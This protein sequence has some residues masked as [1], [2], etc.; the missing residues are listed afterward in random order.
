MAKRSDNGV[1]ILNGWIESI[2]SISDRVARA[3]LAEAIINYA[4][5]GTEYQG[6]KEIVRV[7]MKTIS[8]SVDFKKRQSEQNAENG[9]RGGN[10]ALQAARAESSVN[11]LDNQADKRPLNHS[12]NTDKEKERD[13]DKEIKVYSEEYKENA[14]PST[15]STISPKTKKFDFKGYLLEHGASE[16]AVNDWLEVRKK[17]RA[18]NTLS[19]IR[20]LESEAS[21]AGISLAEAVDMCAGNSWQSLKAEWVE[22]ENKPTFESEESDYIKAMNEQIRRQRELDAEID[23]ERQ[24]RKRELEANNNK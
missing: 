4:Y 8:A 2:R 9:R 24:R 15:A 6:K 5:D 3:E 13:R 1:T 7:M 14:V 10:P 19:A 11:P 20:K 21:K 17:K 18:A 16:Q 22:R 23:A 12:V